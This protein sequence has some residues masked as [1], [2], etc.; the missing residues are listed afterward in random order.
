M[1]EQKTAGLGF[2]EFLLSNP[3]EPSLIETVSK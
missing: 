3:S 2:T 1:G